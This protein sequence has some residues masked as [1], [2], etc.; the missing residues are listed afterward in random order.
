MLE[1]HDGMG[2]GQR[3]QELKGQ[4]TTHVGPTYDRRSQ[5]QLS[6]PFLQFIAKI[7]SVMALELAAV[8]TA[9]RDRYPIIEQS[10]SD[11]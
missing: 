2:S 9:A 4:H 1:V 8:W 3:H 6:F 5:D 10:N 11:P 7:P